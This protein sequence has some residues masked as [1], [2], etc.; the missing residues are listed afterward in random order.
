MSIGDIFTDEEIYHK[1]KDSPQIINQE[2]NYKETC[3]ID[4]E[5][6]YTHIDENLNFSS[7]LQIGRAH[8]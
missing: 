6:L 4:K 1:L 8:V 3:K 2:N 5:K 7:E